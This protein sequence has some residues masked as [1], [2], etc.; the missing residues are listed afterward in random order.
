MVTNL[1]SQNLVPN[2]NFEEHLSFDYCTRVPNPDIQFLKSWKPSG[3]VG[4]FVAYCHRDLVKRFGVKRMKEQGYIYF[5]TLSIFEGNAMVKLHYGENCPVGDTG[6][7]SYLKTKLISPLELGE[8]YEVSMWVYTKIN[9]AADT[10]LYTHIGMYLSRH[11]LIWKS[12]IRIPSD[13]FFYSRIIPGQWTEVKWYIRALCSLEYLT[14]GVFKDETFPSLFRGDPANE[15]YYFVDQVSIKKVNE[16]SLSTD[17]HPTPYCEYYEKEEKQ[18]ILESIT[19]LDV[20]FDSNASMLDEWDKMELDSFYKANLLRKNKIFIITGHTDSEKAENKRLSEARAESVKSYLQQKYNLPEMSL[21]TFGF[22]SSHPIAENSSSSG[23]LQ[24]RRATIRTSDLTV[25]QLFYRKGLEYVKAGSYE[26]AYAQ[27]AKSLR[28]MPLAQRIE[29]VPD[30]RL[31]KMK[32]SKYWT[33]LI[34]SIREGYSVYP[35]ARNAFFLDSLYAEDQAFRIS[36]YGS[37]GGVIEEIDT[38]E[39][40]TITDAVG[41]QKDDSNFIAVQKYLERNAYP[42]ISKVGRR[43]ARGLGYVILHQGDSMAYVRTLVILKDLCIKGEAEWDI[44]AKMSD[45]LSVKRNVTQEY[46][47]QFSHG[48]HGEITLYKID[49]IDEVNKRRARIGMSPTAIPDN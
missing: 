46:G 48:P 15:V 5:D 34:N 3:A 24:N 42:E 38:L 2:G 43:P 41:Q 26:L 18:Q 25:S 22:G 4:D 11:E 31:K 47:T 39:P 35:E 45:K 44:F 16:D 6:C 28:M 40:I 49:N 27:F 8:V 13:Y 37:F 23:R 1:F 20:H 9:P 7:A 10:M 19:A 14:I 30:P 17:I 33:S 36:H 29:I 12:E 32:Q 21:L